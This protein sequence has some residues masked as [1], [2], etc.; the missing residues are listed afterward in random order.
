MLMLPSGSAQTDT[1]VSLIDL[2]SGFVVASKLTDGG[3]C[4]NAQPCRW[5]A[6]PTAARERALRQTRRRSDYRYTSARLRHLNPPQPVPRGWGGG[7]DDD[8]EP[9]PITGM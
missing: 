1:S 5:H 4:R 9:M 6:K 8:V 7:P 3:R 2:F